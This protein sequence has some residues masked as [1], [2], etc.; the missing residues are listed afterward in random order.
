MRLAF[1]LLGASALVMG[2]AAGLGRIGLLPPGDAAAF[3]GALMVS[4]FLGT[5][6]SLERAVAL[7]SPYAYLAPFASG[8]GTLATIAGFHAAA[9]YFWIAAPLLLLGA[10]ARI[11]QRQPALH[12]VLLAVGAASWGFG[13]V[14]DA[15][16]RADAAPAWWFSFLVLTIAAERLEMTR[17][18]RRPAWAAPLAV[19]IAAGILVGAVMSIVDARWGGVAYGAALGAL[20]AWL[21]VFDI[22]RHTVKTEGFA[23]YAALALLG[24]YAWLAVA[25][26]A[27]ALGPAPGEVALHALGLGFVFSMILA[28]APL[29]V[30]VVARVKMRFTPLFY[31]PLVLLHVSLLVRLAGGA[32]DTALRSLGAALNA[33][34]IVLFLA[35]LLF[36]IFTRERGTAAP[37]R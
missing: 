31:L 24:G 28:H 1:L 37:R 3:H 5:V 12:T 18:T 25:G 32:V 10:S 13:S 16:G 36:V 35:A 11:V 22:A 27:W 21:G 2:M 20:A 26:A 8:L 29:I 9:A 19:A 15:S 30:P 6:I 14:L 7:R 23:R 34:A 33:A 4:G 17:L